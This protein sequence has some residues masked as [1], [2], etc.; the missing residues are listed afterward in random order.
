MNNPNGVGY[1]GNISYNLKYFTKTRN[2]RCSWPHNNLFSTAKNENILLQNILQQNVGRKQSGT[3]GNEN[4]QD[5]KQILKIFL[6]RHQKAHY[7]SILKKCVSQVSI[8][9]GTYHEF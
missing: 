3:C 6:L 9:I 4:L 5:L 7:G 2:L 1:S 8:Q